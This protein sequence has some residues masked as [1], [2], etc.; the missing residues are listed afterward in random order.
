[1]CVIKFGGRAH[2]LAITLRPPTFVP[3]PFFCWSYIILAAVDL[4]KVTSKKTGGVAH[5]EKLLL[6]KFHYNC[7]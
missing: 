6:A 4:A 2:V 3:F 1:M 5:S 7:K